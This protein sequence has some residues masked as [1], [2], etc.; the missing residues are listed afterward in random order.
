MRPIGVW[1][2]IKYVRLERELLAVPRAQRANLR[3]YVAGRKL[4]E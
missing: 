3:T 4:T 2:T 1:T